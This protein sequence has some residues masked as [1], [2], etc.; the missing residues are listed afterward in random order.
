MNKKSKNL[1]I[2]IYV[3]FLIAFGIF[4]FSIQVNQ[5]NSL[6]ANYDVV[7]KNDSVYGVIKEMKTRKGGAF[8]TLSNKHKVSFYPSRNYSYKPAFIADFLKTGDSINKKKNSDTIFVIRN[9]KAYYFIH[10]EIINRK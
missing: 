6:K 9:D 2:T 4:I 5:L 7:N 8:L 10:R 1:I 3:I